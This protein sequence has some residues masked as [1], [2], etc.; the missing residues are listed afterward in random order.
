MAP[1]GKR[2]PRRLTATKRNRVNH[3]LD[4]L[5]LATGIATNV[6]GECRHKMQRSTMHR[7]SY[8]VYWQFR[9][10]DTPLVSASGLT[11]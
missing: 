6:L 10:R 9:H 5:C 2:V 8:G 1:L 11:T 7:G 4:T 3:K